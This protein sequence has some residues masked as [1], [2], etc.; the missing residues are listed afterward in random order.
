MISVVEVRKWLKYED[1]KQFQAWLDYGKIMYML[2]GKFVCE[3][4]IC[5]PSF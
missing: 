2:L 1:G 4:S 3:S 5:Q